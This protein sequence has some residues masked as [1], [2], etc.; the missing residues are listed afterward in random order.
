MQACFPL[1]LPRGTAPLAAA[2][3]LA[4]AL[5]AQACASIVCS[6]GSA[7]LGWEAGLQP[8]V[9]GG[10]PRRRGQTRRHPSNGPPPALPRACSHTD[11]RG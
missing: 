7:G 8:C 4:L 5:A 2:T 10:H 6:A 9:P 3:T 1:L 11:C